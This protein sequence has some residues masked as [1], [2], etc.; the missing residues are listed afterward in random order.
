MN[1]DSEGFDVVSSV[2]TTGEIG[3]IE[4]NLVPAFI[5]SHG[6]G[7]NERLDTGGGLIVGGAE[8]SADVLI[9]EHLDFEGEVFF[10]LTDTGG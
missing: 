4:L 1:L 6:H 5:E 9:I 10:E 7:T 3:Q 2:G 8:S